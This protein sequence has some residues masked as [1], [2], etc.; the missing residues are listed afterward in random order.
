VESVVQYV[1]IPYLTFQTL[2]VWGLCVL[3]LHYG[4][5]CTVRKYG[6]VYSVLTPLETKDGRQGVSPPPSPHSPLPTYSLAGNVRLLL[7]AVSR[8]NVVYN[9]HWSCCSRSLL[10]GQLT[11]NQG[12]P[13]PLNPS[14][15]PSWDHSP[16][17]LDPFC[18][19]VSPP[20]PLPWVPTPWTRCRHGSGLCSLCCCICL[21]DVSHQG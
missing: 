3:V 8:L 12:F 14:L 2:T 5:E 19:T 11:P 17:D 7:M 16:E 6:V 10:E 9:V 1:L 21:Q 18:G 15:L 20:P 13:N 4:V